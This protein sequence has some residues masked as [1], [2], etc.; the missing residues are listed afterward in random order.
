MRIL[1][2]GLLPHDSGK[3]TV[4]LSL[5]S[6]AMRRGL[7]LGVSK[8]IS[9]FNGWSQYRF[10][11]ESLRL[12]ILVGEDLYRLHRAARSRDPIEAEGPVV[13]LL[14]PPDPADMEWRV[15]SYKETVYDSSRQTLI[16]RI[17]SCRGGEPISAY[18]YNTGHA[19]RTHPSLRTL[20]EKLLENSEHVEA[21]AGVIEEILG[22]EA[23]I[24]ADTCLEQIMK[25]HENMVI[26]SYN[27]AAAPT[28]LSLQAEAAL[29]VAPG[30]VALYR[31]DRYAKAVN[32]VRGM[33]NPWQVVCSSIVDLVKPEKH[34]RTT[35]LLEPYEGPWPW[36][37]KLLDAI[38]SL[39]GEE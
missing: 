35:P 7:D 31:G 30:R 25:N 9:G 20:A 24:N 3:T 6:E 21:E 28:S 37:E 12:G 32:V 14:A 39:V 4:T 2:A 5:I 34:L 11:E 8:P 18:L 26:E 27:D 29:I 15:I 23:A 13:I 16:A 1:V 19:R 17:T 10:L 33:R 22:Y 36:A 38:L